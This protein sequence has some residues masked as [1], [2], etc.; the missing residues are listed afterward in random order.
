M[1]GNSRT[2]LIV[3]EFS[4]MLDKFFSSPS[5][6]HTYLTDFLYNL[7]ADE[8]YE[9]LVEC[10]RLYIVRLRAFN[11]TIKILECHWTGI[12]APHIYPSSSSLIKSK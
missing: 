12:L 3:Q 4:R 5:F 9:A 8:D 7:K 2:S 6:N 1:S 10:H 11:G